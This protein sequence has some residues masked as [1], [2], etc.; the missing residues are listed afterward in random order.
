MFHSVAAL[1]LD[2]IFIILIALVFL[3]LGSAIPSLAVRYRIN[4]W[5]RSLGIAQHLHAF[6]TLY[7]TVNGFLISK[8]DRQIN[9]SHEFIYGEIEFEAFI[10]ALSLCHPD[11]NTVFYDLGSGVGKAVIAAAMVYPFCRCVGIE[12]LPGLHHCAIQQKTRLRDV[13]YE[14]SAA[15]VAFINDNIFSFPLYDASIIFISSTAF[16]A[17]RWQ[18]LGEH[19]YSSLKEGTYVLSV[20]K[21]LTVAGFVVEREVLLNLSWGIAKLYVQRRVAN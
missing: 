1:Y 6:K 15:N 8:Q 11:E 7:S 14:R 2:M 3:L 12:L 21:V 20:S 9:D 4:R 5:R 19:L 16:F 10:A 18:A 13:G 17:E